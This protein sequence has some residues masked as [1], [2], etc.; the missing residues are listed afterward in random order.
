MIQ[1]FKKKYKPSGKTKLLELDDATAKI[2]IAYVK[3]QVNVMGFK[4]HQKS[5]NKKYAETNWRLITENL[6][7]KMRDLEDG[8]RNKQSS[9]IKL[10]L[11]ENEFSILREIC[12][13]QIYIENPA[14]YQDNQQNSEAIFKVQKSIYQLIN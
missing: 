11:T 5:G 13:N 14:N 10:E 1:L 12:L 8:Q 2:I 9:K 6:I 7:S 4:Y 3:N